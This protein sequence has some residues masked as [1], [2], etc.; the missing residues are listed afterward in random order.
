MVVCVGILSGVT[1]FAAETAPVGERSAAETGKGNIADM[2]FAPEFAASAVAKV[3]DE[4]IT[5]A[6]LNE[7][8]SMLHEGMAKG[9]GSSMKKQDFSE[10]LNRLINS[11]VIIQ[12]A[13]NMGLDQLPEIQELID[14]NTRKTIR[15]K[16]MAERVKDVKADEAEIEKEYKASIIEWKLRSLVFKDEA[17]AKKAAKELKAGKDFGAVYDKAVNGK[18]AEGT[19]DP[20]YVT[21]ASFSPGILKVLLG[22]KSGKVTPVIP[23]EAGYLIFKIDDVRSKEDPQMKEKARSQVLTE[24]RLKSLKAYREEL[25]KKHVKEDRKL[26]DGLDFEAKEPGFEMLLKDTRTIAEIEGMKAVTVSDLAAA[27]QEKFFHGVESAVTEK[28][29]NKAK[30]ELLLKI[31][32]DRVLEK[33]ALQQ[34]LDKSPD[35]VKKV[36]DFEASVLFGAFVEKVARPEVRLNADD[37]QAYYKEHLAEYTYPEMFK[38]DAMVFSSAKDAEA[39]VEKLRKGMDFKWF[40]SNAEGRLLTAPK[41][42]FDGS[43][44]VKT[45]LPEGVQKALT[46]VKAGEYRR[47]DEEREYYVLN[48][49]DMV[50]ARE[51][52]LQDVEEDIKKTLYFQKLNKIVEGWAAK[53]RE[54]SDIEIYVDL[55]N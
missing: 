12:E 55:K 39:A 43:L 15:E 16:L 42:N 2:L 49:L 41:L 45:Q 44:I 47:Y 31:Y 9:A 8:L 27:I 53:L 3:N 19:K 48:I 21:R 32:S 4:V 5:G 10:V 1:A 54:A 40:K 7:S 22:M 38:I 14:K 50:P 34:G 52:P 51:Q 17:Q 13:R 37:V 25:I 26:L 30:Q 28:K 36:A 23:L 33:E 18:H 11:R 20:T 24:A 35:V 6:E 29:V 46:G